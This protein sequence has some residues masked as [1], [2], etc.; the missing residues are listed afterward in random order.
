MG[1]RSGAAKQLRDV[2]PHLVTVHCC[3]HRV[4]LAIKT[5]SS[6]VPFFKTLEDALVELYKTLQVATV[7]E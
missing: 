6:D 3:A 1:I 5:V 7:L 2:V 4:E